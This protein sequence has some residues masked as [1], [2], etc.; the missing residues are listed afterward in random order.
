MA[1]V[2]YRKAS[3]IYPGSQKPAVD[4]LDL[5]IAD[6]EFLVLVGPSGC[7]KSTSLR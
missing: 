4:G 5:E 3:R 6:G 1:T 2:S 7:G